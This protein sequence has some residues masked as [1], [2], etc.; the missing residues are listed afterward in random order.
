MKRLRSLL[1][2]NRATAAA[3]MAL[4]LPIM[5]ALLFGSVEL[6]NYFLSEHKVVKAVR[7]GARFAARRPFSD[8]PGCAP[9]SGLVTDTQNVTRTG[10]VESGGS[11]RL[12]TWTDPN[13]IDVTAECDNSGAWATS[14]IYVATNSPIGTPVVTVTASV[15]YT[16]VLQQLGLANLTL[17]MTAQSQ[18]AVTGI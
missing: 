9:S 13:T 16:T 4:S 18:A 17:T 12:D 11:P 6:G 7:D 1:R 14:G 3:E 10:E 15:P 5:F 8:Y 2:D